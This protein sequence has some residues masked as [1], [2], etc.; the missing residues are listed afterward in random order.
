MCVSSFRFVSFES[1]FER[2]EQMG[3]YGMDEV[4]DLVVYVKL[5]S[6]YYAD[7]LFDA[8]NCAGFVR[9]D[10]QFVMDE[11]GYN[12]LDSCVFDRYFSLDGKHTSS[13]TALFRTRIHPRDYN[14]AKIMIT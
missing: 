10:E 12:A 3:M 7:P 6:D 2:V 13:L 9:F 1:V 14:F 4:M 11:E 5:I 8:A